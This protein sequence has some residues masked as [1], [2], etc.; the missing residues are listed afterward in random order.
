NVESEFQVHHLD[1]AH[2]HNRHANC[3]H[4]RKN[5]REQRNTSAD[6]CQPYQIRNRH[7]SMRE[8]RKSCRPWPA[9]R[10]KQ[11]PTPV[12]QNRQRARNSNQQQRHVLPHRHP[13]SLFPP[14]LT[15]PPLTG[16]N[17]SRG[18]HSCPLCL[19]ISFLL[20]LAV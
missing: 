11:N 4:S 16:D 12:I 2:H 8:P 15:H 7:R 13:P 20:S 14:T 5:P 10:A 3:A 9:K 18:P 19:V 1:R 17:E 6:L